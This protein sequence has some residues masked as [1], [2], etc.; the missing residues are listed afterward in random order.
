MG[1]RIWNLDGEKE[2]EIGVGRGI[3]RGIGS[4][5]PPTPNAHQRSDKC[6]SQSYFDIS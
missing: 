1:K 4:S 6:S 5:I 2:R 3:E